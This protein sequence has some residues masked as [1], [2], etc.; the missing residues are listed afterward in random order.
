MANGPVHVPL[1]DDLAGQLPGWVIRALLRALADTGIDASRLADELADL[2]NQQ[3]RGEEAE[4]LRRLGTESRWI[5][6]R[7]VK[8]RRA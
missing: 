1:H 5:N 2:L 6:R 8:E 4:R 7:Y 3:G